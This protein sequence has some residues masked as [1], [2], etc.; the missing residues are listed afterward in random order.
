MKVTQAIKIIN[1]MTKQFFGVAG[2]DGNID[3]PDTAKQY[4]ISEEDTSGIVQWGKKISEWKDRGEKD[5]LDNAVNALLGRV[6]H[7]TFAVRRIDG[8]ILNIARTT[9][10]WGD[11][12]EKIRIGIGDVQEDNK[13]K[14]EAGKSYGQDTYYPPNVMTKF[15]DGISAFV[16]PVSKTK[17]QLYSA[18]T[19]MSELMS[20][21]NSLEVAVQNA[22]E[23]YLSALEQATLATFMATLL[24]TDKNPQRKVMLLT[25]YNLEHP[26][27]QITSPEEA[28]ANP[29]FLTWMCARIDQDVRDMQCPGTYYNGTSIYP[30]HTPKDLQHFVMLSNVASRVEDIGRASTYNAQFVKLPNYTTLPMWQ[31]AKNDDGISFKAKSTI[32]VKNTQTINTGTDDEANHVY[33]GEYIV[34]VLFDRDA[35]GVNL[36]DRDVDITPFNANGAFWTEYHRGKGRYFIDESENGVVYVL[37]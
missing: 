33:E 23:L 8:T 27:E 16:F 20:F 14:L 28:I 15:Y 30:T 24:S 37:A 10:E 32:N 21:L 19:G 26:K 35:M 4:L 18:F 11:I 36:Y 3:V 12:V 2:E 5:M 6:A 29:T 25:E 34:A 9:D 31:G 17:D 22:M 7:L 1:E 13:W